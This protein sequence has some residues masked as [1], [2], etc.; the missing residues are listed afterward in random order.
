MRVRGVGMK[1]RDKGSGQLTAS[2]LTEDGGLY[3]SGALTAYDVENLCDQIVTLGRRDTSD[4]R[5]EVELGGATPNSP[6][7]L[8]LTRRMKRL[9]KQGVSVRLHTAR[10]RRRIS[11]IAGV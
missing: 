2:A 1:G 5:V 9:R 6:E 10:A 7:M 3:F 11:G 8:S 4:V